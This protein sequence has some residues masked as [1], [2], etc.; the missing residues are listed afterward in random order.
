MNSRKS[1]KQEQKIP[2][3]LSKQER[4]LII[5]KT[6]AGPDLTDRLRLTS[7][8]STEPVF[9]FTLDELDELVGY[10]AAEANHTKSKRLE[11]E[12]DRLYDRIQDI[13]DTHTD[14]EE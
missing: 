12:L 2:V 14:E 13:L 8:S 4:E 1:Q 9:R 11:R 10:I 3:K 5:N 7:V 6:F